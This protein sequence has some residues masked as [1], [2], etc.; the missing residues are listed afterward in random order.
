MIVQSRVTR[1]WLIFIVAATLSLSVSYMAVRVLW[2]LGRAGVGLRNGSKSEADSRS[3]HFYLGKYIPTQRLVTLRDGSLVHVP[4]AW[5]E[6]TW[7]PQLTFLLQDRRVVADGYYFYIPIH[8]DD[9]TRSNTIWPFKF[10]IDLYQQGHEISR[11]PGIAYNPDVGF[12]VF[13]DS[14]PEV[15]RFTV[16]QKE[17]ESDTWNRA[18]PV[19]TIEFKRA[20]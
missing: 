19:G 20:F 12:H 10:G 2:T 13:L 3:G 14:L 18:T 1:N 15:I 4:D 16:D 8:P 5:A 11:Y 9:S 7:K 17:H 6:R